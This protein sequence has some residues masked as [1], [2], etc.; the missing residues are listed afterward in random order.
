M[1]T[2]DSNLRDQLATV[3]GKENADGG[4]RAVAEAGARAA[5]SALSVHL[6][7]PYAHLDAGQRQLRNRLRQF[8]G[9][10]RRDARLVQSSIHI[11]L[12]AHL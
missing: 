6:P 12:N 9:I 10:V 11:D 8:Q 7:T 5:L 4:A 2:L 3:V 1:P